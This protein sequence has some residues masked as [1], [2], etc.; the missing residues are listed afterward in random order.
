[1]RAIGAAILIPVIVIVSGCSDDGTSPRFSSFAQF[2]QVF[3]DD[4]A[5]CHG[6]LSM[7]T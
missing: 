4:C 5:S 3:T 2:Q 7:P 6:S 1:M